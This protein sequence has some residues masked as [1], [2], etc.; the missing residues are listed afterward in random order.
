ML[1][2][3]VAPSDLLPSLDI[4]LRSKKTRLAEY[5]LSISKMAD[6]ITAKG[7]GILYENECGCIPSSS[8][9]LLVPRS[10]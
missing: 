8:C 5:T 3:R 7:Q 2:N 1:T 10:G 9:A 4:V 6:D